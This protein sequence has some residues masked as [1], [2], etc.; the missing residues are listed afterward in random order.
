M[1]QFFGLVPNLIAWICLRFFSI[2]AIGDVIH[3]PMLAHK[4]EDEGIICVEGLK[5]GHG[6]IDYNCVPSVVYTHPEVAW[7]GKT[8]EQLKA[9]GVEYK[10][11]KFPF[12]ANSRA[13]TNNDT[14]GFVKVLA[15]KQTDRILGTHL[16]G[17]VSNT[18]SKSE[19]NKTVF[20]KSMLMC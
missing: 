10:V 20:L 7:V 14:D 5:G 9:E 15:D 1:S 2:Y 16:I 11:G 19:E 13:K 6:H 8:E 17:P 18:H 12:M 3:G 4:A